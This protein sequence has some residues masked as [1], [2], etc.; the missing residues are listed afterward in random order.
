MAETATTTV[1][2][3]ALERAWDEA[4]GGLAEV[5]A[6]GEMPG[7][8]EAL[9]VALRHFL[10]ARVE[11]L[12]LPRA[13]IRRRLSS[14]DAALA[15]TTRRAVAAALERAGG[16]IDKALLER[17]AQHPRVGRDALAS[18]HASIGP[19]AWDE[20]LVRIAQTAF[21]RLTGEPVTPELVVGL[22]PLQPEGLAR[23]MPGDWNHA[24]ICGEQL[25]FANELYPLLLDAGWHN[26]G[27]TVGPQFN[28]LGVHEDWLTPAGEARRALFIDARSGGF[29]EQPLARPLPL[30]S[31]HFL[32]L[33]GRRELARHAALARRFPSALV[34][35]HPQ[36]TRACDRK[37]ETYRVLAAAGVPTPATLF[38]PAGTPA[39]ELPARL[40]STG[41]AAWSQ[42]LVIQP[43]DGSE[44]RGV[45]VFPPLHGEAVDP[46]AV[47]H[48]RALLATGDVVVRERVIGQ[49][50]TEG[51]LAYTADLRVN[52][53]WDGVR[54][55]AESG[56]L[57]VASRPDVPLS[58][59]GR[60][61][62]IVKLSEG[63]LEGLGL[64]LEACTEALTLAC[65]AAEALGRGA[66]EVPPLA[67]VGLDL[68]LAAGEAGGPRAWVLDANPR[69]AGLSYAEYFE[70]QE[71]GPRASGARHGDEDP[72]TGEPG[73]RASGARHGDEDPLVNEPGVSAGLWQG[74]AVAAAA[75]MAAEH[76]RRSA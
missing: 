71:P 56:Y 8:V 63:A 40:H 64:S 27:R 31:V 50:F 58:S 69:P 37:S 24:V 57:Q 73:P 11:E 4:L 46:A 12:T 49:P 75:T 67:L 26:A 54:Y 33:G 76:E 72:E 21:E 25:G 59:V 42:G 15:E 9:G 2:T 28:V 3:S 7:G 1:T 29:V 19:L 34:L 66:A 68:K 65:A 47:Q 61:G 52:A 38:I 53:A 41:A 17:L 39:E 18:A 62:R 74:L 48:L 70:G 5:Y 44:G 30:H 14:G 23:A 22:G 43:D 10:V 55:R 60:G 13:E 20:W 35:N 36:S 32:Y 6:S 51:A 45:G 16:A